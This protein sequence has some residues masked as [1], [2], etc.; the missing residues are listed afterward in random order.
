MWHLTVTPGESLLSNAK[1]EAYSEPFRP[2]QLPPKM[3]LTPAAAGS[4]LAV[5]TGLSAH[6]VYS[7]NVKLHPC[8]YH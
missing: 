8:T 1:L 5:L 6:S 4:F 2:M 7:R 3:H